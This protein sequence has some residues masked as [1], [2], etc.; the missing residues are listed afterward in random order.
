MIKQNYSIGYLSGAP[1]V[2][3]RSDAI[4][5]GPRSHI[6]GVIK[7]FNYLG[8]DVHTYIVGNKVPSGWVK[9]KARK[10]SRKNVLSRLLSDFI[11]IASGQWHQRLAF[12]NFP[13][14]DF[15]YERFGSF[16]NLGRLFQRRGVKWI[17][18]TNGPYFVEADQERKSLYLKQIAQKIEI[19]AYRNCDLLICV[20]TS[21][22]EILVND[23]GVDAEKVFI[24]P[25]GVDIDFF[26]PNK[27]EPIRFFDYPII[28]YVGAVIKRQ[29]LDL[30]IRV[31]A[32]VIEE[33]IIFGLVIVGEGEDRDSL[34]E[35]ADQLNIADYV[36]FVGQVRRE[37]VPRYIGGFDLGFSGQMVVSNGLLG[38]MYHSPL[39]LYEYLAMGKP[40]IASSYDDANNVI[41]NGSTGFL[42]N[43]GDSKTLKKVILQAHNQRDRWDKMSEQ[44]RSLIIQ[45]H[46][47]ER[48]AESLASEIVK[49]V[50]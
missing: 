50:N 23:L 25:N 12:R 7:G 48:R 32:E 27:Y 44:A 34:I 17:L 45:H 21:L 24:L 46:S 1:S 8:W 3:T 39:K 11:R 37:D 20:S 33:G 30:L 5:V 22:K 19:S 40:V 2:S 6:L 18:E 9:N 29:G 13:D 41:R 16:Q 14:V 35:L 31:L 36:K 28:G 49:L 10:V 42:F 43:P 38:K 15:V 4:T 26:C 47:W